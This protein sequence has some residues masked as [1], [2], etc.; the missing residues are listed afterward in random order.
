MAVFPQYRR[1]SRGRRACGVSVSR[2]RKSY[3]FSAVIDGAG[4]PVIA[5][6]CRQSAHVAGSPKKRNALKECAEAANVFAVR[7]RDSCFGHTDGFPALVDP[8]PFD[9]T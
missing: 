1:N 7:V 2:F 5:A 4:L 8:A 3:D 9:P 6:H